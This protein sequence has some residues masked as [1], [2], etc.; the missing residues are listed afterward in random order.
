MKKILIGTLISSCIIFANDNITKVKTD[1]FD[2]NKIEN[3]EM[4]DFLNQIKD[5]GNMGNVVK[6]YYEIRTCDKDFYNKVT[7][8]EIKGFVNY[9]PAFATLISLKTLYSDTKDLKDVNNKYSE[10]INTY[11]F[12]NCGA[13]NLPN[14]ENYKGALPYKQYQKL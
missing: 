5:F 12:L 14:K 1:L 7:V 6:D 11:K 2:F 13:G 4:K 10:L 9:S 3:A 8:E